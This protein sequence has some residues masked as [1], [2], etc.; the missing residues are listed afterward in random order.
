LHQP[1]HV[2]AVYLTA[3]GRVVD[4]DA[5]G[6]LKANDTEGGNAIA[7]GSQSFHHAW[8]AVPRAL[9]AD[10]SQFDNVVARA[11]TIEPTR[12][13]VDGWAA[14]WATDTIVQGKAAFRGLRYARE[15]AAASAPAGAAPAW[16]V[17]G[18]RATVYVADEQELKTR[19][20]AAAGARL[21]QL[22]R[23]I[24]PDAP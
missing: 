14:Q 21:A 7:D 10:G 1:L 22:L 15:P 23:T 6:Y 19:Q 9:T 5:T 4:P 12:G 3:G 20:L 11:R 16:V 8:D 2:E 13:D 18:T 24:W 17:S